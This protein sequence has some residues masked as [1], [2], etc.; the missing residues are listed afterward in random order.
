[1][2]EQSR[3]VIKVICKGQCYTCGSYILYS[4]RQE[5][6]LPDEKDDNCDGVVPYYTTGVIPGGFKV[7]Y[8]DKHSSVDS[9]YVHAIEHVSAKCGKR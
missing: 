6:E 7:K 2:A 9:I 8:C 3:Q 4:Y 5:A 1:M